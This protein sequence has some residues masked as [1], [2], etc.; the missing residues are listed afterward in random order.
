M[1]PKEETELQTDDISLTNC[2]LGCKQNVKIDLIFHFIRINSLEIQ[3]CNELLQAK[4]Q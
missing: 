4:K 3:K 1:D 2:H